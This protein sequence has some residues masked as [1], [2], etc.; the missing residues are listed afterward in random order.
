M[1]RSMI[2]SQIV[3]S[4]SFLMRLYQPFGSNCV[5]KITEPFTLWASMISRSSRVCSVDTGLNRNSSKINLLIC[6][7]YFFQRAI[8]MCNSQLIQQIWQTYLTYLDKVPPGCDSKY[9][10]EICFAIPRCS[11]QNAMVVIRYIP[12]GGEFQHLSFIRI[13][14]W[15]ILNIFHARIGITEFSTANQLLQL[16]VFS[17]IG[18]KFHTGLQT[19]TK[20]VWS[21]VMVKCILTNIIYTGTLAQEKRTT[22][23]HKV[24]TL[25]YKPQEE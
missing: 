14:V 21:S 24:K 2:A 15:M 22:P 4:Q 16:C 18:S 3:A 1:I 25:I 19:K 17:F 13:S 6:F 8:P 12:A 23:K 20:Y 9:T 11:F 7:D 5:Q 10:G